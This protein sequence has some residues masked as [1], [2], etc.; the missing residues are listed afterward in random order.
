LAHYGSLELVEVSTDWLP[1][2]AE[3]SAAWGDTVG[4]F[5]QPDMGPLMQWRRRLMQQVRQWVLPGYR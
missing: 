5:R 3:D 4:V 2:S 1:H